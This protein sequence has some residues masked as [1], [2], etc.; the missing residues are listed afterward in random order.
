M[1]QEEKWLKR[2]HVVIGFVETN[3]RNPSKHDVEEIGKKNKS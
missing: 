3:H 1:N 2:Y